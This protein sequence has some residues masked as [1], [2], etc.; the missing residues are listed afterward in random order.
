[1]ALM[2]THMHELYRQGNEVIM[3]ALNLTCT[4]PEHLAQVKHFLKHCQF[5]EFS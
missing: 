1:M 2:L 5:L 3:H 4:G